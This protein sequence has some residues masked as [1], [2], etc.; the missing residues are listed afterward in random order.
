M[1][2]KL[3][4]LIILLIFI[5]SGVPRLGRG[6]RPGGVWGPDNLLP[7]SVSINLV[8]AS[9][10][11]KIQRITINPNDSY[12]VNDFNGLTDSTVVFACN[13][14]GKCFIAWIDPIQPSSDT[15]YYEFNFY[16]YNKIVY[17]TDEFSIPTR[18]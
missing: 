16:K 17:S 10:G 15:K 6:P 5:S 14:I 13:K 12:V 4:C 7:D 8:D 1:I 9:S 2:N 11:K 3:V 18:K